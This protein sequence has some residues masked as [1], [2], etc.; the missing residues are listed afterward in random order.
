MKRRRKNRQIS[1]TVLRWPGGPLAFWPPE[2]RWMKGGA[3]RAGGRV[4]AVEAGGRCWVEGGGSVEGER[5]T[6]ARSPK[7]HR[8]WRR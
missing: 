6:E 8:G 5:E 7:G 4:V 2:Q 3:A 1:P